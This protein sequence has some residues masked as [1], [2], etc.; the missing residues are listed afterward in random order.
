[1]QYRMFYQSPL[2][3]LLLTANE[4][5]LLK[6]D[7]GQAE[8]I[9]TTAEDLPEVLIQTGRWLDEYFSGHEPDFTPEIELRGSEFQMAVW[10][11]LRRIPY[12]QLVTYG[13]IARQLAEARGLAHMSAQAVGGA[14]GRNPIA[15]IVPCHR[16]IG[17]GGRL[18]GYASGLDKKRGL[19]AL[20]G[21]DMRRFN[22]D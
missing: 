2:G 9:Q 10:Q 3:G 17:A 14:V 12:G 1:M 11:I 20:E 7:F 18:T 15:I 5:A 4:H 19:L 6:L 13:E 16:V 21:H 8:N 22:S